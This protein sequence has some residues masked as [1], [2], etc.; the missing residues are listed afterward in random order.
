[1]PDGDAFL[2]FYSANRFSQ[3]F[4]RFY[5]SMRFCSQVLFTQPPTARTAEFEAAHCR[6]QNL[7]WLSAARP[8]LTFLLLSAI[9]YK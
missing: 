4:S 5:K 3:N 9:L 2:F 8:A 7:Q 6:R 1:V